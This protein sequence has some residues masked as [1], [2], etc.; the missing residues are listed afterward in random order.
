MSNIGPIFP[1]KMQAAKN[2]AMQYTMQ[3]FHYEEDETDFR[4]FD[5]KG[6]PWFVLSDVARKIG[7]K[8]T[9]GLA[10]RLDDDEKG[11]ATIDTPGGRQRVR[12]INE[13]GLY[14]AILGSSKPQAK[15]F[16]K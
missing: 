10:S 11:V 9:S 6:E 13:S 1:K 7:V 14:S 4:V 12:I 15:R 16:K 3:L 8:N 5:R 2:V